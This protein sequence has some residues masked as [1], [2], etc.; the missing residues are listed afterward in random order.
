MSAVKGAGFRAGRAADHVSAICGIKA[1][2]VGR[3]R[4]VELLRSNDPVRLSYVLALL[5][6][7]GIEAVMLDFHNS[8]LQGSL[9]ILPRR[10]MVIGDDFE[11]ARRLLI[12]AGEWDG[13][14]D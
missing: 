9:G 5:D 7:A 2:R 4:L 8:I 1:R 13:D 14:A 11:A 6:D 10:L 3:N 12:E